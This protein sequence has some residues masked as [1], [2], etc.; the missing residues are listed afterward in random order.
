MTIKTLSEHF[1]L[2]KTQY[3]LDFVDVPTNKGD[4]FLLQHQN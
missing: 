4:I 3:E 2:N 1:G